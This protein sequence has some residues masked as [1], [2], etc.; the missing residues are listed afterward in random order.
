MN[1]KVFE[2]E[3]ALITDAELRTTV[4]T[5]LRTCVAERHEHEPASSTGKYHPAF[6]NGDGGLVRH[7]KE[8]VRLTAMLARTLN[9]EQTVYNSLIA[10]AILH[11]M[12]KYP[13]EDVRYTAA[14]HPMLMA[15]ICAEHLLPEVAELVSSHMGRWSKPN[16]PVP[17]SPAQ[18]VLHIADYIASRKEQYVSI[19]GYSEKL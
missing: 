15:S 4:E 14:E 1:P 17:V 12:A 6:A 7:T 2:E 5:I 16:N 10:A 11:D 19:R 18:W 8:V 9:D 3:L 13:R